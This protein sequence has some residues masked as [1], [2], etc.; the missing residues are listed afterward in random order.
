MLARFRCSL[1]CLQPDQCRN[2]AGL[3][4]RSVTELRSRRGIETGNEPASMARPGDD[5]RS[6]CSLDAVTTDSAWSRW[7]RPAP[8]LHVRYR[9]PL[10]RVARKAQAWGSASGAIICDLLLV[11]ANHF[12][13][14]RRELQWRTLVATSSS[15]ASDHQLPPSRQSPQLRCSAGLLGA[16]PGRGHNP[17]ARCSSR[18]PPAGKLMD[19][20]DTRA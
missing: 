18:T 13:A 6:A 14:C 9:M 2:G 7:Y 5:T 19:R 16:L 3:P 17:H 12:G 1:L 20:P 8:G 10:Q 11:A 15:T 4:E